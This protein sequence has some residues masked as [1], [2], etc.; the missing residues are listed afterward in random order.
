MKSFKEGIYL[1]SISSWH[2][3][4]VGSFLFSAGSIVGYDLA[5]IVYRG[6]YLPNDNNGNFKGEMWISEATNANH[7][8]PILKAPIVL[9]MRF[10][11]GEIYTVISPLGEMSFSF[12]LTLAI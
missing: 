4:S 1:A 11:D 5:G 8:S 7:I 6:K 12:E 9:P 3:N 2:G 10:W